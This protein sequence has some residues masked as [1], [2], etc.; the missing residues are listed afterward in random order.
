MYLFMG[1]VARGEHMAKQEK[2]IAI[3]EAA[4]LAARSIARL[5]KGRRRG[6]RGRIRPPRAGPA[7]GQHEGWIQRRHQARQDLIEIS[8]SDFA[9]TQSE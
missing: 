5:E 4:G 3:T 2:A 6:P 7:I 1:T 8:G 9:V